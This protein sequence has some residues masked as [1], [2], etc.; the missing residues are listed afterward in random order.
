MEKLSLPWIMVKKREIEGKKSKENFSLVNEEKTEKKRK[1]RRKN[2]GR[3]G[4][5]FVPIR[6]KMIRKRTKLEKK[7][8][9]QIIKKKTEQR[10][11]EKS[12]ED[13][14]KCKRGNKYLALVGTHHQKKQKNYSRKASHDR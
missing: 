6:K 2:K 1:K 14:E 13:I 9:K 10:E 8:K 4:I 5:C 3:E 12:K 11:K 7:H